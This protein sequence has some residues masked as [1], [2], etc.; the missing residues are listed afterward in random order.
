VSSPCRLLHPC[1]FNLLYSGLSHPIAQ[2]RRAIPR[3]RPNR[4]VRSLLMTGIPSLSPP[5]SN[6]SRP[7][8]IEQ[9]WLADTPLVGNLYKE[10]LSSYVIMPAILESD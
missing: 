3:R 4:H 6:L 5:S 8:Q 7:T 10:P 1:A 2:R 9:L